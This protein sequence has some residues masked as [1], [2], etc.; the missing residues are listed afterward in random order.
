MRAFRAG[1]HGLE[2]GCVIGDVG[3]RIW[4]YGYAVSRD[5]SNYTDCLLVFD[6]LAPQTAR[7]GGVIE[8]GFNWLSGGRFV[9]GWA[10]GCG[11]AGSS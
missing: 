10:V 8:V 1:K 3:A 9:P 6:P 11:G 4:A 5:V 7:E 2:K